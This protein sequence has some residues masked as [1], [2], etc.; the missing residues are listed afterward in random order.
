VTAEIVRS[1]RPGAEVALGA[2]ALV[3]DALDELALVEGALADVVLAEI[4]PSGDCHNHGT[5]KYCSY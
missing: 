5:Q 4:G 3:E 1:V 2:V